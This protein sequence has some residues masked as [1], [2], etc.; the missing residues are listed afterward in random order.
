MF[1]SLLTDHKVVYLFYI[2]SVEPTDN[3][4]LQTILILCI[5]NHH[6][7]NDNNNGNSLV[8]NG[9]SIIHSAKELVQHEDTIE[10]EELS[11]MIER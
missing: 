3:E 10:N 2:L 8:L 5:Q 9:W 11:E 7:L 6:W 4:I 1:S